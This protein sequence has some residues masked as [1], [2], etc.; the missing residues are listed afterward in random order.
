M[1]FG[2]SSSNIRDEHSP[3]SPEYEEEI[4]VWEEEIREWDE[5]QALLMHL[6]SSDNSLIASYIDEDEQPMHKGS[7]HGHIVINC[8]R[9]AEHVRLWNDCFSANPTYGKD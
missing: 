4:R 6:Y 5:E 1:N 7:I 9:E 2:S 3:Q 8:G